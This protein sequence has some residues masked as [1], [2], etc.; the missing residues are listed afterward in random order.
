MNARA[1]RRGYPTAAA[2][3][4]VARR[5]PSSQSFVILLSLLLLLGAEVARGEALATTWRPHDAVLYRTGCHD[6]EAAH[7][8]ATADDSQSKWVEFL[9]D[10][11][12]FVLTSS[13]PARLVAWVAGPYRVT[14]DE[15][16]SIW[17]V[18]DVFGDTEFIV[19]PDLVG[20][21]VAAKA[22]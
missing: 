20:P 9:Q 14:N 22:A 17:E 10:G 4:A 6:A 8:I 5:T 12:C 11:R 16:A 2:C 15:P 21:H 18:H 3:D 1:R 19:L 7:A 13:T